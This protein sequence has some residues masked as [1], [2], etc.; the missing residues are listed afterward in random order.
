MEA[1]EAFERDLR[2]ALAHL[3]DPLYHPPESLRAALGCAPQAGFEALQAAL[4]QAVEALRPAPTVPPTAR[5]RRLYDLLVHRYIQNLSQEET[6]ERLGITPR[7]LRRE[8]PEAVRALAQ[9]L[10]ERSGAQPPGVPQ[11]AVR[12]EAP[13]AEPTPP[14][15][16]SQVRQELLALQRSAPGALAD[17]GEVIRRAIQL[18]ENITASYGVTLTSAQIGR[19]L[20]AAVHPTT[21]QQILITAIRQLAEQA[22][23]DAITLGA[24]RGAD[25][26]R[27]VVSGRTASAGVLPEVPFIREVLALQGGSAEAEYSPDTVSLS[28]TLPAVDRKVLVVDDNVD[29]VHVFRRYVVGTRYR[30]MHLA[31]GQDALRTIEA[32]PPDVVVLDVM[33]PDVDGWQ[34]LATLH[35]HPATRAIPV[36]VCSVVREEGLA[37]ALGAALYLPKPVE[38][39]QFLAALEQAFNQGQAGAPRAGASTAAAY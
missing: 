13:G 15:W 14:E 35:Q 12:P 33:L 31:S 37:M 19:D 23:A 10:W 38:R 39:E 7:H 27:I 22:A 36:V 24:A 11:T 4:I 2:D 9:R 6:A 1:F 26:V 34:L 28:L 32:A 8:Q 5:S 18:A 17:V 3:Y 25:H 20:I 16:L 29:L 30:I 21:L